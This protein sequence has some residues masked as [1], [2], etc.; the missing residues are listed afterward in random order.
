MCIRDRYKDWGL[1]CRASEAESGKFCR[2]FQRLVIEDSKQV[3]LEVLVKPP[4]SGQAA[5]VV[6]LLPLGI[7]L[8]ADLILKVDDTDQVAV[9]F[10]RCYPDGCVARFPLSDEMRNRFQ[11]GNVA[12]VRVRDDPAREVVLKISLAG[13]TAAYRALLEASES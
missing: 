9:E 10:E 1:H 12:E 13:F 8:P 2:L 6:M 5:E 4:V 3:A 7:F 11:K